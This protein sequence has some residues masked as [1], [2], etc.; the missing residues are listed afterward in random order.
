M[1]LQYCNVHELSYVCVCDTW[2]MQLKEQSCLS[3]SLSLSLSLLI[4][5]L[6]TC[7]VVIE[8][9]AILYNILQTLCFFFYVCHVLLCRC[10][11]LQIVQQTLSC[12]FHRIEFTFE[13]AHSNLFQTTRHTSRLIVEL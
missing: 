10:T 2:Y 6:L 5:P 9:D 7:R 4:R 8:C 3:L 13:Y 12:S 1:S 11:F